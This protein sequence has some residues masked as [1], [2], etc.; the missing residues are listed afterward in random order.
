ML[1]FFIAREYGTISS[2]TAFVYV[3]TCVDN[4]KHYIGQTV[5]FE[6][7]RRQHVYSARKQKT[8]FARAIKEHGAERFSWIVM[9]VNDKHVSVVEQLM[10]EVYGSMEPSGY[11]MMPRGH[12]RRSNKLGARGPKLKQLVGR[13]AKER[14][15]RHYSMLVE[16]YMA[17]GCT[18]SQAERA[19]S[20][21]EKSDPFAFRTVPRAFRR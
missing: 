3:A 20:D 2:M 16:S 4:G 14:D 12:A 13:A 10:I 19:A 6:T 11:N 15:E 17:S 9:Q 7:R 21:S 18:R 1:P 5:D 8:T